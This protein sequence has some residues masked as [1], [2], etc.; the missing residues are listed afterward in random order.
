MSYT[1]GALT[2]SAVL[3]GPARVDLGTLVSPLNDTEL[4]F[5]F[6]EDIV[7][8]MTIDDVVPVSSVAAGIEIADCRWESWKS[9]DRLQV[10]GAEIEADNACAAL[11]VIGT[12]WVPAIEIPL[13]DVLVRAM[14]DGAEVARGVLTHVMGHP[15]QAVRWLAAELEKRDRALRAGEVVTTG[16][17]Y[18]VLLGVPPTGGTWSAS[19]DGVGETT[20]TLMP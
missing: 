17:P 7:A 4:E 8:T 13:P 9:E 2:R 12:D 19:I 10:R 1:W 18:N 3:D 5:R 6:D 20:V 11:L 15:A 16:N 14:F